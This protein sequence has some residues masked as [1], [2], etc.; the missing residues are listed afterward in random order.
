MSPVLILILFPVLSVVLITLLRQKQSGLARPI[1]LGTHFCMAATAVSLFFQGGSAEVDQNGVSHAFAID[2]FPALG[3]Q[4]YIGLDAINAPIVLMSCLVCFSAVCCSEKIKD[5]EN[6]YY[7]LLSLM[8]AGVVGA[9]VS[10]DIFSFYFFHELALVPTFILIGGWGAGPQKKYATYKITMYLTGGALVAL[11]GIILLYLNSGASTFS[12][13]AILSALAES[14]I[15]ESTQNYI[16]PLLLFG[17]GILV[18]LWPMHTWAPLGYGHAPTGVAMIHA[19]ALK[20]FGLYGLLRIAIPALP[21]GSE[22]WTMVMAWL[23]TGNLILVGLA[24]IRQKQLH[25]LAGFSSV[26]H[27]GFVFMGLAAY[28]M[29]GVSGALLVMVAHG[30]LAALSFGLA[31]AL[32][33]HYPDLDM[34]KMG[35][36][37]KTAPFLGFSLAV[38]F[39][40]GCGV[41][42]FAN[43]AG[44]LL[45]FF[46]AWTELPRIVVVLAVWSGLIIGGVYMLRAIRNVLHGSIGEKWADLPDASGFQKL[47]FSV[48]MASLVFFGVVPGAITNTANESLTKLVDSVSE[49]RNPSLSSGEK[50]D[51]QDPDDLDGAVSTSENFNFVRLE[52][53]SR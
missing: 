42:G 34:T 6:T 17:F 50:T 53:E 43:F 11:V 51:V 33:D 30:F 45:I 20:K 41:P 14:P 35:G 23:C 38:A 4:F 29:I 32:R 44:E 21:L 52:S 2:W 25:M 8:T 39:L 7:L 22:N 19:G 46:G 27:M 15:S 24:T 16:F 37:L 26:A 3:I 13:F 10:F 31:G 1:A 9:F 40:A 18:S 5:R 48:L 47:A 12:V 36:I 49:A 28:N